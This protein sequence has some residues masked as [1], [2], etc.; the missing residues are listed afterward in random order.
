MLCDWVHGCDPGRVPA[1]LRLALFQLSLSSALLLSFFVMCVN[2]PLP[3][4]R[5]R[6]LS[7]TIY[8]TYC[9]TSGALGETQET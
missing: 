5:S 4:G 6:V 8:R 2:A 1:G 7:K 9:I 3:E